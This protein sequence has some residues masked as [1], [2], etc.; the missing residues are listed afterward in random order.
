LF[1]EGRLAAGSGLMEPCAE[2]GSYRRAV[3]SVLPSNRTLQALG[4]QKPDLNSTALSAWR[5][6]RGTIH[7]FS[8]RALR[9]TGFILILTVTVRLVAG[10]LSPAQPKNQ[11]PMVEVP[12]IGVPDQ[13]NLR[14]VASR[15][16]KTVYR[17]SIQIIYHLMALEFNI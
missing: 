6:L 16:S 7:A 10:A 1:G 13:G 11:M 15:W 3:E 4:P 8:Q 9:S 2:N 14:G 12:S 17:N 5:S